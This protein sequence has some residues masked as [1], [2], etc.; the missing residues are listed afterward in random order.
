MPLPGGLTGNLRSDDLLASNASGV[1]LIQ[2]K[3]GEDGNLASYNLFGG[4]ALN[5]QE[6]I[7]FFRTLTTN[8]Q[9]YDEGQ[10]AA[11][12][13]PIRQ[14]ITKYENSRKTGL[15]NIE[16]RYQE[17]YG[18]KDSYKDRRDD[19]LSRWNAATGTAEQAATDVGTALTDIDSGY[20]ALRNQLAGVN[21]YGGFKTEADRA[22]EEARSTELL[23]QMGAD[24]TRLM[25]SL[26]GYGQSKLDD[27]ART[28]QQARGATNQEY[29]G[30]GLN[31]TTVRQ[32]AMNANT[33]AYARERA[34]I[35]DENTALKFGADM[36][37]SGGLNDARSQALDRRQ[38]A[39]SQSLGYGAMN[40]QM[41]QALGTQQYDT[42]LR[43]ISPQLQAN[44]YGAQTQQAAANA[45]GTA[46]QDWLSLIEGKQEEVPSLDA[47]ANIGLQ[48]GRR[49]GERTNITS[50]GGTG[51]TSNTAARGGNNTAIA[52][53]TPINIPTGNA[54]SNGSGGN[55]LSNLWGG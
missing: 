5:S 33:D 21:G 9:T 36:Q 28:Y 39:L 38:G 35:N 16:G 15:E 2:P 54:S 20:G 42:R 7:D 13:D 3:F 47:I 44:Q 45:Y 8:Q 52:S 19:L 11:L 27:A 40:P 37:L 30:R 31:N 4:D 26:D 12:D 50:G 22:A 24:R 1:S 53:P 25:S 46:W 49:P 23:G 10:Q 55:W 6:L 17:L 34:R 51:L 48:V 18:G 41:Q 14:L 32:N 43:G 29:T